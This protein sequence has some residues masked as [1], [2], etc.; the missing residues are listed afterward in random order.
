MKSVPKAYGKQLDIHRF[1]QHQAVSSY[2]QRT[3][4]IFSTV[5]SQE[6]LLEIKQKKLHRSSVWIK[7]YKS[8]YK[9]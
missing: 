3:Q 6:K 9:V 7:I 4:L 8:V 1:A 2:L 5:I